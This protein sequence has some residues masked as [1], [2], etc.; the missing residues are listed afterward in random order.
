MLWILLLLS[1]LLLF[2]TAWPRQDGDSFLL[3]RGA[4]TAACTLLLP[5]VL[6]LMPLL[7]VLA[8]VG[9][10]RAC[11]ARACCGGWLRNDSNASKVLGERRGACVKSRAACTLRSACG[12][13]VSVLNPGQEL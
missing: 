12:E 5:L 9:D 2:V 13:S 6:L 3:C 1:L 4:S 11:I 8:V 7:L 10:K